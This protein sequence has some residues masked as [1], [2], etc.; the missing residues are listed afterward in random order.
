MHVEWM[1]VVARSS[2]CDLFR[3]RCAG[4]VHCTFTTFIITHTVYAALLHL[5]LKTQPPVVTRT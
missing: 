1:Q 2:R 5:T 3:A 4:D